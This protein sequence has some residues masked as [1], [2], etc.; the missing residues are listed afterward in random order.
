MFCGV[1]W[2]SLVALEREMYSNSFSFPAEDPS[3]VVALPLSPPHPCRLFFTTGPS[4]PTYLW[5]SQP[6]RGEWM[7]SKHQWGHFCI[8]IKLF[9][10]VCRVALS[11][12]P[13]LREE[14]NSPAS[15][16][17]R[18]GR[19]RASVNAGGLPVFNPNP[20]LQESGGWK[21]LQ[22]F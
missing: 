9:R 14:S 15:E 6:M 5:R 20:T 3:A 18:G 4:L 22:L 17:E 13:G 8:C 12:S 19:E 21:R 1:N 11:V 10:T 16:R 7:V 2:R